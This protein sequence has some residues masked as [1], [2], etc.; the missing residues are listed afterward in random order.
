MQ[1]AR[2]GRY[3]SKKVG[4]GEFYDGPK[5]TPELGGALL[6]EQMRKRL[7]KASGIKVHLLLTQTVKKSVQGQSWCNAGPCC[8]HEQLVHRPWLRAR[9]G[10]A[11]VVYAGRAARMFQ[12]TAKEQ[13]TTFPKEQYKASQA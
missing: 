11:Q 6:R 12:L 9:P 3:V 2:I 1:L 5:Q 4:G 8:S 10:D 13:A 7:R